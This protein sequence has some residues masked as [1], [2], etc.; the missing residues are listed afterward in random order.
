[1]HGLVMH[2]AVRQGHEN[3]LQHTVAP[4]QGLGGD[5]C[6]LAFQQ[7]CVRLDSRA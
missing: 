1:M 6:L 2:E 7:D 3:P 5:A 4:R